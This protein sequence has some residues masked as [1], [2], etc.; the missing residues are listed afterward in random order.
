PVGPQGPETTED[1]GYTLTPEAIEYNT[2][3]R[4]PGARY[5]LPSVDEWYKAAYYKGGSLDAGYWLYPTQSDEMPASEY[6]PGGANSAN[7]ANTTLAL[8]GGY[9]ESVGPYGTYDQAGNVR[10]WTDTAFRDDLRY[11][12]G[13]T[14]GNFPS[15]NDM[16]SSEVGGHY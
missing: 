4:N 16:E 7:Y 12:L 15:G 5:F 9:A 3:Q 6:P 11:L 14:F 8:V 1:G 10:E 13:G 2:W